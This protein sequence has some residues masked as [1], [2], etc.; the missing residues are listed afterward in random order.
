MANGLDDQLAFS[1]I[2]DDTRSRLRA[3]WP[4]VDKGLPEILDHLY[5]HIMAR[6]ELQAMFGSEERTQTARQRQRDHWQ[7]LFSATFDADYVASVGRIASTHARIGLEP[8]F[9]ICTYLIALEGIHTIL[10]RS[11]RHQILTKS[12]RAELA[13]VIRAVDRAVVFDLQLVVS[14]YLAEI[15]DSYRARL[16][17]LATQIGETLGGF[18]D[19]IR[20]AVQDLSGSSDALLGST[21]VVTNEAASLAQRA[22]ES[23]SNMQTVASAAEEISASI[24]E[25]TRQT[26]E[27]SEVTTAAV[28]TVRRAGEIVDTLST[29]ALRIGDVVSLIQ[30]IAGQ[31]NLLALNATIEA[32]RAGDAGKGFA[33]VAGEVK[34]LSAQTARATDDIRI[35]VN[36]VQD[37]VARIATSMTDITQ[38][39]DR[40]RDT[41]DSI[42]GAVDQQGEATREISRS[43]AAAA[44]SASGFSEGVR[45]IE[46]SAAENGDRARGLAGAAVHMTTKTDAL[47][48]DAGVLIAQLRSADRRS[49]ARSA[50][51]T[52][53]EMVIAG[54]GYKAVMVNISSG[55]A[56]IRLDISRLPTVRTD[57][58]LRVAGAPIQPAVRFINARAGLANLTFLNRE[59]GER[60]ERWVVAN[61]KSLESQAA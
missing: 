59:E 28:E 45:K 30:N 8:S 51:T 54:T 12:A 46:Q 4:V 58:S 53:C 24:N 41:T 14:S 9:Y 44:S 34:T 22:E 39:V 42:A 7:H 10:V 3:A 17:S 52:K 55:G 56:A 25:I 5:A 21:G 31:T 20:T 38:A 43:V 16:D 33:V 6:P 13:A 1:R 15:S 19:D 48:A 61:Q 32:A 37:V 57:A 29:T 26:R 60:L 18:T 50:I 11:D 2:D 40:I 27:A 36:A 23:S 47:S 35:Q 49:E